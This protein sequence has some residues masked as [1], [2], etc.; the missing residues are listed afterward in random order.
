[1]HLLED[2]WYKE[3]CNNECTSSC[4][5]Y[6]EMK[7]LME[8]SNLPRSKQRPQLLKPDKCDYDAFCRL[9]DIKSDIEAFVENGENLYL[10]SQTTGN[11][12]TTW[13][14]K[15]LLKY[16][17]KVWAGNGFRVRGLFIHVPTFLAQLKNFNSID[18]KFEDIKN[19]LYDV[20]L[21]IWDDIASSDLSKYD[22]SQLITYIDQR[23]LGDK[24]NI[25]TSNLDKVGLEN[26]L[27]QR[28]TS[29][30]WNSDN[31]IELKGGDRR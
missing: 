2:C 19:L 22:L 5:R 23:L 24:S 3:V 13:A 21:V 11:G 16:F 20:D 1:M 28:L 4:I 9:G 17:D 15:L 26:A 8:H 18:S 25:F 31:V 7:F 30:I 12:K 10:Y 14:I 6:N 27:G 29:R